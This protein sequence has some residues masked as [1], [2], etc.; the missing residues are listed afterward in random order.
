MNT[1]LWE[2]PHQWRCLPASDTKERSLFKFALLHPEWK[3]NVSC[4]DI[5]RTEVFRFFSSCALVEN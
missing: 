4:D 2:P 3:E 5:F 1:H